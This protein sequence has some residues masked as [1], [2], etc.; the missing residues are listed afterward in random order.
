MN[1]EW[2]KRE[3]PKLI[4]FL[5][6]PHLLFKGPNLFPTNCMLQNW[7][8]YLWVW[9]SLL[10][11]RSA[12]LHGRKKRSG[13][14]TQ[15]QKEKKSLKSQRKWSCNLEVGS[16]NKFSLILMSKPFYHFKTSKHFYTSSGSHFW[17]IGKDWAWQTHTIISTHHSGW[18]LKSPGSSSQFLGPLLRHLPV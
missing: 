16:V 11:S 7:Q 1:G 5:I 8:A 12:S 10:W 18:F 13:S 6:I 15:R 3:G 14:T 4:L 9:F 17:C 2:K